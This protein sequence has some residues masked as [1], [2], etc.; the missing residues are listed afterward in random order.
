MRALLC[1]ASVRLFRISAACQ[2][3]FGSQNIDSE[4]VK[5][6]LECNYY[7]TLEANQDLLPLVRDGG[8][9]VNVSSTAGNLSKYSPELQKQF[10]SAKFTKDTTKLMEDFKAAVAAGNEKDQ[11]WVSAAYA[12]SK[13]GVT[14]MTRC[15][16]EGWEAKGS[17]TLINSCCPGWV[18]VS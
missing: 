1:K 13:A 14:A 7:G 17:K 11:G 10:R 9:L 6:T 8:R 2:S 5:K 18:K 3:L 12:T 4:V 16:A 15:L